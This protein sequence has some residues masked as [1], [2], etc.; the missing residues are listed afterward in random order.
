VLR[1]SV[2]E[3]KKKLHR[4]TSPR[5]PNRN[6][7]RGVYSKTLIHSKILEGGSWKSIGLF[8]YQIFVIGTATRETRATKAHRYL[9]YGTK[10]EN[11]KLFALAQALT[12]TASARVKAREDSRTDSMKRPEGGNGGVGRAIR[13][14]STRLGDP[15]DMRN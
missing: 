8:A 5:C 9:T 3:R 12:V 4:K 2:S 7:H 15:G 14:Y 1:S 11:W 6:D 10:G 13:K